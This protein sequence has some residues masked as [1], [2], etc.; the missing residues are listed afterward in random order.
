[1]IDQFL[2]GSHRNFVYLVTFDGESIVIDPWD[3]LVPWQTR[4]RE[5]G[6]R[7][8]GVALTHTHWDHVKGVPNIVEQYPDLPIYLH[9]LDA[10][11]M[12][13][14][15]PS[16]L[17]R[18]KFVDQGDLIRV[19]AQKIEVLHTPGHSAGECS[20]FIAGSTNAPPA[21]FTGDT[22]FIGDVGR[23]DLE[24]GSTEQLFETLQQL[25]KLPPETTIY[26]GHHYGRTPTSTLA[27]EC[28][29]SAAFRCKTVRELD[30]LP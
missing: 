30:A 16:I 5:L 9:K 28:S 19:G 4:L 17:E 11:R 3:D 15:A 22:V 29:E 25:K 23:T 12:E 2:I 21:L 8:T 20:Y 27:R 1:M 13:R 24:T 26:P 18:F 14:S 6:S 10:R 7:L